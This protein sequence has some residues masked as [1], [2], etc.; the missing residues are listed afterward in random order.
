MWSCPLL[1]FW[2]LLISSD[3]QNVTFSENPTLG[4]CFLNC[5]FTIYFL[6]YFLEQIYRAFVCL[7]GTSFNFRVESY[8]L[9]SLVF[10]GYF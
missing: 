8:F 3:I 5:L 4:F 6:D 9:Q 1:G 10:I 7:C 2:L